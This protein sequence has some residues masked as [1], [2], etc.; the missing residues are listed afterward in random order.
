MYAL[1]GLPVVEV[2]K[3]LRP[4]QQLSVQRQHVRPRRHYYLRVFPYDKSAPA[5]G[6]A[7]HDR[8][9]ELERTVLFA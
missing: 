8:A 7:Q 1:H 4:P 3:L 2:R 9:T 5:F 6:D